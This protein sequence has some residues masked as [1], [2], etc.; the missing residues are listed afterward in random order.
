MAKVLDPFRFLL[1]A[2]AGWMNQRQVRMIEY[3]REKNLVLREQIV[4]PWLMSTSICRNFATIC[5]GVN[6]FLGISPVPF[7]LQ[8]LRST[9]TENTGQVN[10]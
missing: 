4:L 7:C 1:I 8:S 9:G 2:V 6:A 5:S 3:L 10:L